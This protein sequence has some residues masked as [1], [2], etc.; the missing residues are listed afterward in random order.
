MFIF[1]IIFIIKLNF[2]YFEKYVKWYYNWFF[3]IVEMCMFF[4]VNF[5][6]FYFNLIKE[7]LVYVKNRKKMFLI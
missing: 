5:F 7:K 3:F 6:L 4:N 2:V 1:V